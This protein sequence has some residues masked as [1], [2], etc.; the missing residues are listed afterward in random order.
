MLQIAN[1]ATIQNINNSRTGDPK[2]TGTGTRNLT[3]Q[4]IKNKKSESH[5]G[6][7]SFRGTQPASRPRD[8]G[9]SRCSG[10]ARRGGSC[11]SV[12]P[13][14]PRPGAASAQISLSASFPGGRPRSRADR[15]SSIRVSC[16]CSSH[17]GVEIRLSAASLTCER[18]RAR[19][20]HAK[21]SGT[22]P[23][24]ST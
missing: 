3:P 5:P 14:A 17:N 19:R 6:G 4:K 10:L 13:A 2:K 23:R 24:Q 16:P 12:L 9:A 21:E 8:A 1:P 11:I 15:R 20:E 18:A 7:C 22:P